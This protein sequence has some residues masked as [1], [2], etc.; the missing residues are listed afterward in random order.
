[1]SLRDL[2]QKINWKI[3]LGILSGVVVLGAVFFYW[4]VTFWLNREDDEVKKIEFEHTFCEENPED[5]EMDFLID[6][7][8]ISI[9][10][11]Y[12]NDE[13]FREDPIKAFSESIVVTGN[14]DGVESSA[15]DFYVGRT[16]DFMYFSEYWG[17][18][19]NDETYLD[20]AEDVKDF[21]YNKVR[22]FAS[23]E[24][25]KYISV[26]P[27][28]ICYPLKNEDLLDDEFKQFVEEICL[29]QNHDA[30]RL[31]SPCVQ[32]DFTSGDL[33]DLFSMIKADD[34]DGVIGFMK[35][36]GFEEKIDKPYVID[37]SDKIVDYVIL[38]KP[39]YLSDL[40]DYGQTEIDE[41][42]KENDNF[43]KNEWSQEF[44]E[45]VTD[46]DNLSAC[47]YERMYRDLSE[48]LSFIYTRGK[49]FGGYLPQ[50]ST[51]S[52]L[53][54]LKY[55]INSE[56]LSSAEN[57]LLKD[58][59]SYLKDNLDDLYERGDWRKNGYTDI[60][61]LELC[62]ED[63]ILRFHVP[64]AY[65][66]TDAACPYSEY[67]RA[68]IVEKSCEETDGEYL[69]VFQDLGD[70]EEAYGQVFNTL[71]VL[72]NLGLIEDSGN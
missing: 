23:R 52:L 12:A 49:Q 24:D 54:S 21:F 22:P 35:E 34:E 71:R 11:N 61:S 8:Y 41:L 25:A 50:D 13:A 68:M 17:L 31:V 27:Y 63:E 69:L 33:E 14:G 64:D 18:K 5:V 67:M 15:Q 59:Y 47:L 40:T 62:L 26:T 48:S 16:I 36:N 10:Y 72:F 3:V 9:L 42:K 65:E 53:N 2:L 45:T 6:E 70:E 44:A 1:M 38:Q 19:K 20:Y 39:E 58:I 7:S 51:I 57:N 32:E 30:D 46:K 43:G 66:Q 4:Y 37:L 29:T 28:S 55:I 56:N 60:A